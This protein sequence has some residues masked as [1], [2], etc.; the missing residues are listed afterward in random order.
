MKFRLKK[1]FKY[2]GLYILQRKRLFC[3]KDICTLYA[4]SYESARNK[5][6]KKVEEYMLND[7]VWEVK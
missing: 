2:E 5:A 3:W 7:N 4:E 6:D 1:N